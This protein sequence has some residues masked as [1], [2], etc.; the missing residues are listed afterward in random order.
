MKIGFDFWNVITQSPEYIREMANCFINRGHEVFIVS[1][2]GDRSLKKYNCSIEGYKDVIS[3]FDIPNSG[4]HIVYF[5]KDEDIPLLKLNKC[6]ELG[7]QMFF[8]DRASTVKIL[9]ENGIISF[10][11]QKPNKL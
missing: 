9:H 6:K 10:L 11:V 5:E 3:A 1:A 2:V 7:I 4:I 8:D